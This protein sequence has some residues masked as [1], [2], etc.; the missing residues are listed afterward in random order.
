MISRG[1]A[2]NRRL[3][4]LVIIG[5]CVGAV[6]LLPRALNAYGIY[7]L[8]NIAIFA[9]A[10]LGL[11]VVIGWSGQVALAHA[12][13]F[14]V[15]AYG[16]AYAHSQGVP[17]LAAMILCA[18]LAAVMGII[19][20]IPVA[21]LRGLYLAI[22]TLAFGSLIIRVFYE[23]SE[24]TGG[25]QGAVVTPYSIGSLEPAESLWYLS[26]ATLLIVTITLQH[27]SVTRWGRCLRAV[28]DAEIATGSLGLS[29]ASYKVQAFAVSA[30][31][32][33]I[34]GAF[35]GQ[36]LTFLTP[37]SFSMALMI[38]FLIVVLVGGVARISGAIIGAVFLVVVHEFLQSVGAYQRLAFGLGLII[39]VRF[40]PAGVMVLWDFAR[41]RVRRPHAS[42]SQELEPSS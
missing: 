16:T 18:C 5:V 35:F 22:A 11:T 37:D 21:R 29:A 7:I 4:T 12:G 27:L 23:W 24:V 8:T 40:L 15:G 14:G 28:R 34:S 6:I 3:T 20:G 2:S 31:L 9:I 10:C 38:E 32:G 39:I 33:G 17:W 30:F 13:F 19:I 26:A 42:L 25:P 1:L 36:A 41:D